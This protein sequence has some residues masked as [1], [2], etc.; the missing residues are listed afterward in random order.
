MLFKIN[1]ALP[2]SAGKKPL[3]L[4]TK[5]KRLYRYLILKHAL[6]LMVLVLLLNLGLFTLI[7][8]YLKAQSGC[9]TRAKVGQS[10]T[11]FGKCYYIFEN[12]IYEK[13]KCDNPHKGYA[14]GS[15][16]TPVI[17]ATHKA[18]MDLYLVPN[19]K[20]DVCQAAPPSPTPVPTP[21]P[22]AS[23]SPLPSASA[24]DQPNPSPSLSASPNPSSATQPSPTAGTGL[25]AQTGGTQ[26]KTPSP[27]P[28]NVTP[29]VSQPTPSPTFVITDE[30]A[31]SEQTGFGAFLESESSNL[32]QALPSS[33]NQSPTQNSSSP[34]LDS[35]P[36]DKLTPVVVRISL[37]L[38]YITFFIVFATV[39][40]WF[41]ISGKHKD[42]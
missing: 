4:P 13:G 39:V 17:P 27:T 38:T 41:I 3:R 22:A 25:P 1:S 5:L 15:D 37:W 32:A 33:D 26:I 30:S 19:Y 14:C 2:K 34:A 18:F 20:A 35:S 8:Y 7:R 40:V 28:K 36:S 9:L 16:I 23:P 29:V 6:L 10:C 12:K 24:Q 42:S 21:T 11:N 31:D